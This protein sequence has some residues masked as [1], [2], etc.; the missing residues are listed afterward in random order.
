M[1]KVEEAATHINE[2]IRH[3][4]ASR[5][6]VEVEKRFGGLLVLYFP[7]IPIHPIALF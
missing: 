3:A 1:G 6:L 5:A 7:P 2:M 4:E